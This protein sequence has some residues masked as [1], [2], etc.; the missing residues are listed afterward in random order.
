MGPQ[1]STLLLSYNQ[2][3]DLIF[4]IGDKVIRNCFCGELASRERPG[5][6]VADGMQEVTG[7]E[8]LRKVLPDTEPKG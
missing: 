1:G 8:R 6:D 3:Q 7:I 5:E 2:S 4:D